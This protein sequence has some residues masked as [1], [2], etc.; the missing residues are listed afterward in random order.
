MFTEETGESGVARGPP[1]VI[2][3]VK[4][5]AGL[6]FSLEGGKDSPLGDQ[7]LAIKKIFTGLCFKYYQESFHPNVSRGTW[8]L[9]CN[10]IIEEKMSCLVIMT[11]KVPN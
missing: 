10:L 7:P 8:T 5:G 4:D 9:K 2:T 3:L 6:G 1:I 11:R